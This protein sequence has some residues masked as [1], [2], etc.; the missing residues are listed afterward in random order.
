MDSNKYITRYYILSA[1]FYTIWMIVVVGFT[2]FLV[3]FFDTPYALFA[4]ALVLVKP[5]TNLT[6]SSVK[7]KDISDV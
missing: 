5:Y 2:M 7:K 4:L 6:V 1:L 3:T